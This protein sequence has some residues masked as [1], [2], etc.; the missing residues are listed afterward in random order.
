VAQGPRPSSPLNRGDP[1]Y[2]PLF[3]YGYG[4]TYADRVEIPALPE[5]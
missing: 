3:A 5:S 1:G 2:D 4:L